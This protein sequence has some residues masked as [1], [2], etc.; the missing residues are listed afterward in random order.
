MR[1]ANKIKALNVIIIGERELEENKAVF[2]NMNTK[3]QTE[4]KLD[5]IVNN[6]REIL[7]KKTL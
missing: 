6:I 4:I 5:N 1:K 3:E 7:N 2:R